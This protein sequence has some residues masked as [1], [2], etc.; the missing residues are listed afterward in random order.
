[1]ELES[2]HVFLT[3]FTSI[4]ILLNNIYIICSIFILK[5]VQS[6]Y[7]FIIKSRKIFTHLQLSDKSF[8]Y[9]DM[10]FARKI[11]ILFEL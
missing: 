1:M 6:I 8:A 5:K 7:H 4:V 2:N 11:N 10:C 9:P 3:I